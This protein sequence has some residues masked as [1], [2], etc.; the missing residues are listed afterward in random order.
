MRILITGVAGFIGSHLANSLL[1]DGHKVYG[2]DSINAY[3][4]PFIKVKR[5]DSLRLYSNFHFLRHDLS[6]GFPEE[7]NSPQFDAVV[8]LAAQA[9]V[10]YSL[11]NPEAYIKAN[12]IGFQ[13]VIDYVARHQIPKFIYASSSSVYGT[14][15]C[16]GDGG[17][18]EMDC[19]PS[20]LYGATKLSNEIVAAAYHIS[21]KINSVGFRFFSVYGPNGR[22]DMFLAD[23]IKRAKA[24]LPIKLNCEDGKDLWR[25]WTH[26]DDIARGIMAALDI[27]L[28]G[29]QIF[30]L[31]AGS[32]ISV[33]ETAK[34]IIDHYDGKSL[35][36]VGGYQPG[37]MIYTKANIN[38]A[39]KLLGYEPLIKFDDGLSSLFD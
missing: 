7:W 29:A 32:P 16:F 38:R 34:K 31:G 6:A 35:L 13:Q 4:D 2:I 20:N 9:G 25:D 5:L 1:M 19:R 27:D 24:G 36:T 33:V 30:N 39:K 23:S 14:A 3:Y 37:E 28:P 8:H 18:E 26:V 11:T 12:I 21:H 17:S 15:G 10:R 22:P